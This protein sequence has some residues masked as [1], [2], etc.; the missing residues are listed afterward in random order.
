[1]KESSNRNNSTPD[2][3][4][5][6]ENGEG[7]GIGRSDFLKRLGLLAGAPY[8]WVKSAGYSEA[9]ATDDQHGKPS[10]KEVLNQVP[11]PVLPSRPDLI[12]M[13]NKC[14][15]IGLK[16]TRHG[17][18]ENG[19]V[20]WYIDEA[21]DHRIFQWDTC[22]SL[23]WAKYSQG[24]LPNIRSLD[25]F[26]RKQHDDGAIDGVISGKDGSDTHAKDAVNYTRNN[27]F[28]WS[29][30]EYYKITGDDSRIERVLPILKDYADWVA[31][32][33]RHDNGHYYWSGLSSGMD[34]SPRSKARSFYPPYGW[35]D[36]NGNEALAAWYMVKLAEVV[37]D[38]KIADEFR[39][40]HEELIKLVNRDMWNEEDRFYWDIDKD[41]SHMKTKT[42][43]SFW[44]MWG[45]ITEP[46][47]VDGLI[48]HLNDP[49]SFNRPHRVPTTAADEEAYH[50]EGYY[51][52]GSVWAPTNHMIVKGL[53]ANGRYDMAREITMNR[54]LN[55]SVVFR[56]TETVW[57]NYSPEYP[58][59]GRPWS[60]DDFVGWSACAP[61]AQLIENYIGLD[62]Q[63]PENT[64]NWNLRTIEETGLENLKF[65]NGKVRLLAEKREAPDK[66]INVEIETDTSF[67]FNL[68]DGKAEASRQIKPG[69]H[70]ITFF[71]EREDDDE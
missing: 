3:H 24:A 47:H 70:N 58:I 8:I 49:N 61:V 23:A 35:V 54:L 59:P 29:E 50:P 51:W 9:A 37:G 30:W 39:Q 63:A 33:R 15:E 4:K 7:N 56:D 6:A 55:Q 32:H 10:V 27:L 62:I 22:F 16:N 13:Y 52:R 57:E 20:D 34:N 5:P 17:N 65:G 71:P 41:G 31:E 46:E 14:W 36:Y 45:R 18:E 60:R 2:S 69:K 12:D 11:H 44:P 19:F 68:N 26:Y 40:R 43:A 1:M 28:S 48:W 42:V 25:N 66:P 21:F 53:E 64:I 38:T 67:Y